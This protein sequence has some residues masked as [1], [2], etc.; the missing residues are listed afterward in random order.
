MPSTHLCWIYKDQIKERAEREQKLSTGYPQRIKTR[1]ASKPNPRKPVKGS[2]SNSLDKVR[3]FASE[4]LTYS[5][6]G[7]WLQSQM[8][9]MA[10]PQEKANSKKQ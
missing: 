5:L 7:L 6:S 3:V 9:L 2:P 1:L 8:H 4:H 10:Q